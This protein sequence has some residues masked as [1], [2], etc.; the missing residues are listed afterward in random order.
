MAL[1]LRFTL[2]L[3][4]TTMI[5]PGHWELVKLAVGLA[6]SGALTPLN[7]SERKVLG[8]IAQKSDPIF[9]RHA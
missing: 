4:V 1:S 6:Q 7:D 9:P 3:P 2:H 8:E 5:P